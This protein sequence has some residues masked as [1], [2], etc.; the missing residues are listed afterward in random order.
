[1]IIKPRI[2]KEGS[3]IKIVSTANTLVEKSDDEDKFKNIVDKFCSLGLD[4]NYDHKKIFSENG[5]PNSIKD[6]IDEFNSAVNDNY[7]LIISAKG[8]FYSNQLLKYIDYD[9]LASKKP[10]IC[11]FSDN[12]FLLNAIF[13]KAKL[14]TFHGP[15]FID[16]QEDGKHI[17]YFRDC[18]FS[19]NDIVLNNHNTVPGFVINEGKSDGILFGGNLTVMNLLQGSEFFPNNGKT[20]IVEDTENIA[21]KYSD[22]DNKVLCLEDTN[23]TAIGMF[24]TGL[25]SLINSRHFQQTKAIIMGCSPSMIF[26]RYYKE[27]LIRQIKDI[28]E[29]ENIPIIGNINFGHYCIKHFR[30]FPIGGSVKIN[31]K[32]ESWEITISDFIEGQ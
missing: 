6:R 14:I 19:P 31:A 32:K 26:H 12:T 13:S 30:T 1:M 11:G 29:L 27:I 10:I 21:K 8:G 23:G 18:L 7:K 17:E 28:S 15:N 5:E 4:V 25:Q 3:K 24:I 9:L 16:F 20:I 2:L 22:T